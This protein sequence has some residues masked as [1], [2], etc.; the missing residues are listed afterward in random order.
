MVKMVTFFF[1]N[2]AVE[3][4]ASHEIQTSK[5]NIKLV[6]ISSTITMI[7]IELLH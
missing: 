4:I 3:K 5:M 2:D 1:Q 6:S 7:I